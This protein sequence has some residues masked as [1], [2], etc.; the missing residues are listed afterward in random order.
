MLGRFGRPAEHPAAKAGLADFE[1]ILFSICETLETRR[2]FALLRLSLT[3]LFATK[4]QTRLRVF[5]WK[6]RFRQDKSE[7][8]I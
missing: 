8:M 1:A 4:H 2:I 7:T 3:S 6:P 5:D